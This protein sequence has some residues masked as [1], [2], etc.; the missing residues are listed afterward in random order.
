ML[1][2][3]QLPNRGT[4]VTGCGNSKK[5]AVESE[6]QEKDL[7]S[8][9]IKCHPMEGKKSTRMGKS[10][11]KSTNKLLAVFASGCVPGIYPFSFVLRDQPINDS[12]K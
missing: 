11:K 6:K 4:W 1:F 7:E 8:D 2:Q 5:K 3:L 10:V 9:T 12:H